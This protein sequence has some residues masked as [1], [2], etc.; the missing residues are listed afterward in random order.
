M[1]P[2]PPLSKLVE[3][4]V[5]A[6]NGHHTIC[7]GKWKKLGELIV[8]GKQFKNVNSSYAHV[9]AIF[10]QELDAM[11]EFP[12]LLGL[13]LQ[14]KTIIAHAVVVRVGFQV[15]KFDKEMLA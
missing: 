9:E 13:C 15:A 10:V 2:N 12:T 5:V 1:P 14:F 4:G 7:S 3:R 11:A 6:G 8:E